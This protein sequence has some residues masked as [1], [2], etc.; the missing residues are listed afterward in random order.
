MFPAGQIMLQ[1]DS[2]ID[3]PKM[4]VR[5]V[6]TSPGIQWSG[7]ISQIDDLLSAWMTEMKYQFASILNK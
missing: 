3:E 4:A 7:A 1:N 2:S 6:H 5:T